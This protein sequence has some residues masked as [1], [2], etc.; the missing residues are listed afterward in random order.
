MK[1]SREDFL[2]LGLAGGAGMFL[3][4]GIWGCGGLT[5]GN[6]SA[7]GSA[8]T[9]LESTARLPEPFGVPLPVPPVLEPVRSDAS[10]DYYEITQ[11]VGRAE[12]LPGRKTEVWGYDGIF[13]GPTIESRRGR[14]MIV[15]HRNE[16]DVP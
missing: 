10:T 4:F 12:I 5:A 15:R 13:P 6:N 1:I 8:G 11:K 7:E 3:P 2:R 16:L 9:L 14:R